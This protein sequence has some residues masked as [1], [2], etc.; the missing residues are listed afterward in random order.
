MYILSFF[1]ESGVPKTGLSTTVTVREVPAGTI[2]VNGEAM[3]ELGDGFY[4]YDFTTYD[5]TK[6]YAILA[7]GS[8]TLVN[9]ERYQAS[10][11]ENFVEDINS[12]LTENSLLQRIVGLLH[13]NIFIDTPVYD[14]N[15]NL[16][17]ARVRIYS[18]AG[19]V[20]TDS[21]IIGTYTITSTGDGPG[22]FTNWSQVI[23]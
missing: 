1:T 8:G 11:N 22:K 12:V 4:Y 16:V 13:E 19:S 10:G 2:E 23:V 9:A 18:A 20:G 3:L 5:Y 7:D 14:E 15:N 21:D 17:S 6:D